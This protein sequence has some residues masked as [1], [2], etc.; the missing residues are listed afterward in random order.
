[1]GHISRKNGDKMG[2]FVRFFANFGLQILALC[3]ILV[4]VIGYIRMKEWELA[5]SFV[6]V[7]QG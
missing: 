7:R 4:L 5:R 2:I 3:A 1:M 6:Y